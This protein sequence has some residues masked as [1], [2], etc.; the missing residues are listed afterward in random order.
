MKKITKYRELITLDE[1]LILYN[2]I[3]GSL[4]ELDNNTYERF[5]NLD[6]DELQKV[7]SDDEIELL[8]NTG[9]IVDDKNISDLNQL[10]YHK[11]KYSDGN[12][13]KIDIPITDECNFVCPYCFEKDCRKSSEGCCAEQESMEREEFLDE[14]L[15]YLEN[16]ITNTVKE[17]QIVWYGGEPLLEQKLIIQ[18]GKQLEDFGK[19]HNIKISQA[20][21]TNGFLLNERLIYELAQFNISFIQITLDGPEEIHNRTR[22][23]TVPVNSYHVILK[24]ISKALRAGLTII[25]RVNVDKKNIVAV[26]Q[27]ID[28][29][30]CCDIH[31]YIGK[32]LFFDLAR[33]FGS[34]DSFDL[35]SY[36]KAIRELTIK[37]CRLHFMKPMVQIGSL[38]AFCA[39]E[40]SNSSYVI[41]YNGNMYKCWN[42]VF[43]RAKIIANIR[44]VNRS[45]A[46]LIQ[47]ESKVVEDVSLD[48]LND[49]KCFSCKYVLY[50]QGM[51]PFVRKRIF[52][53][54]E[55]DQYHEYTVNC[56]D[57]IR[58]RIKTSIGSYFASIQQ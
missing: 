19:K 39:A 46:E 43:N 45:S 10:T 49:R 38:N 9:F 27:L 25:I 36:E 8:N 22:N 23:L 2:L 47:K 57:V 3:N 50:C 17:I 35:M 41:D 37:A 11:S 52:K 30:T 24:N 33:I 16:R 29:L 51:C 34:E 13:I 40:C 21:V 28:D 12:I 26:N 54:T 53:K 1:H 20:I 32:T 42:N 58:E 48:N 6:S 55:N 14:L 18:Y 5:S 4:L 56:M 15:L 44:N 7:L 31:E